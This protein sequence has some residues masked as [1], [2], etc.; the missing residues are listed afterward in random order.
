MEKK[1]RSCGQRA[2]SALGRRS[3]GRCSVA[4]ARARGVEMEAI[5]RRITLILLRSNGAKWSFTPRL[6]GWRAET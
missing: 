1:R 3:C 5:A 6:F 4:A 2:I